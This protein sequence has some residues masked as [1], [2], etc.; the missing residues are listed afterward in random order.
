MKL[1]TKLTLIL[2]LLT[3]LFYAQNLQW[4]SIY[5]GPADSTDLA[6]KLVL[7]AAGNVFVTGSSVGTGSSYDFTTIKYNPAGVQ[8]WLVRYN[9]PANGK[10][11]AF[12]LA[13]DNNSNI[14]VCGNSS[15]DIA[16]VKYNSS[17]GSMIWSTRYTNARMTSSTG[18]VI[19]AN[20]NSYA[21]GSNGSDM[22]IIKYNSSGSQQ[23]IATYNGPS[24]GNDEGWQVITD[25]SGNVFA[26]GISA[27]GSQTQKDIVLIKYNSTGVQQWVT[28]FNNTSFNKDDCPAAL[29]LDKLGNL[30]IAGYSYNSNTFSQPVLLLCKFNSSGQ[31]MWSQIISSQVTFA[32]A[33]DMCIDEYNSVYV[34]GSVVTGTSSNNRETMVLAKYNPSGAQQWVSYYNRTSTSND[35]AF[36]I[37][38][39]K[40]NYIYIQNHSK[41]SGS[42]NYRVIIKYNS[43]GDQIWA[44]PYQGNVQGQGS[45][46]NSSLSVDNSFNVYSTGGNLGNTQAENYITLKYTQPCYTVS[47]TV[48]YKDNN[49]PVNSGYI[50]ALYYDRSSAAVITLDSA[51]IQSNGAYTLNCNHPDSAYFMVYQDD[52]TLDFVPT[53]YPSTIDWQQAQKVYTNQNLTNINIQV[54]RINNSTS[55]YSISGITANN[56]QGTNYIKDAIVYAKIGS[57]FKNFALSIYDG[58]Y[59]V[60]KLPAGTYTLTAYRMGYNSVTQTVTI[61][62]GNLSGINFNFTNPIGVKGNSRLL[63]DNYVL[64]QNYPNPFNPSTKISFTIPNKELVTLSVYDITGKEAAVLLNGVL[65]AG[66]H[67]ISFDASNLSSGIYFYKLI[68]ENIQLTKKMVLLK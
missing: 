44:Q 12:S 53:Y 41:T 61:T 51:G 1:I 46:D 3:S 38:I 24:N 22:I 68:T 2:C 27:G 14:Y 59:L 54:F 65:E 57:D 47:G 20:G 48:T 34:T 66:S 58:S 60:K 26:A 16:L 15:N 29:K 33:W 37:S 6:N 56:N 30:Y 39:D 21:T 43:N 13:A 17:N 49:Q 63:P 23:W 67:S 8:Q 32:Q 19:D 55:P 64:S 36:S 31:F 28:R 52:E 7:D 50:K 18:F 4:Q 40:N 35:C 9:G 45:N 10:D 42:N 11:Y 62:T 25:A 5:N